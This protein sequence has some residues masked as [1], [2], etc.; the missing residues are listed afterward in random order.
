[1]LP[2]GIHF[3]LEPN[4]LPE[5]VESEASKVDIAQ[6]YLN[7]QNDITQ[8]LQSVHVAHTWDVAMEFS[9]WGFSNQMLLE[10]VW[11]NQV[12]K[13]VL[14]AYRDHAITCLNSNPCPLEDSIVSHYGEAL[15]L[16]PSGRKLGVG[17]ETNGDVLDKI[18]FAQEGE[19]AMELA[20]NETAMIFGSDPRFGGFS[21]HDTLH[22]G[23]MTHNTSLV[24]RCKGSWMW[25][26]DNVLNPTLTEELVQFCH[27][28]SINK[29]YIDAL[30]IQMEPYKAFILRMADEGIQVQLL[31]ADYSWIYTQNHPVALSK[32]M[33]AVELIYE[34][35]D[36]AVEPSPCFTS[37]TSP[38]PSPSAQVSTT[39]SPTPPQ[40]PSRTPSPTLQPSP[41]PTV[42]FNLNCQCV[43]VP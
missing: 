19:Y 6:Q 15:A 41:F 18:S 38:T 34:V 23:L 25:E 37:T 7:L 17:V 9:V 3:D 24:R 36:L 42:F 30:D 28:K 4:S 21:V 27:S 5:W 2:V 32:I 43:V 10:R 12:Q 35:S 1:L 20:F 26:V 40:T 39:Q 22:Y 8:L 16:T 11:D 13:A 33:E 31:L 14:L 29:L